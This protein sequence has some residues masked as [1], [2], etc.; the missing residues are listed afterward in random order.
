MFEPDVGAW[1]TVVTKGHVGGEGEGLTSMPQALSGA[2]CAVMNDRLYAFGGW[3]HG[4]RSNDIH[5]LDFHTLT[6]QL[7]EAGNPEEGPFLK[8]KAAMVDYGQEMLCVFGGYGYPSRSQIDSG[9]YRGQKGATYD[10]DDTSPWR[11]CWMNELH[12]FHSSRRKS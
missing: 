8:D 4:K 2:C 6:W 11:I 1:S 12:V 7:L 3:V 10:W 9:T 5:E